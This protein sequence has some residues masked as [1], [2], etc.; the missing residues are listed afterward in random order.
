MIGL[1]VTLRTL[2]TYQETKRWRASLPERIHDPYYRA[3]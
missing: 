1:D 3:R 2:L